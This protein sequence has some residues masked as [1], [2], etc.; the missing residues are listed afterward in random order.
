MSTFNTSIPGSSVTSVAGVIDPDAYP[1]GTYTTDWISLSTWGTLLALVLAGDLGAAATLDAK[2][3][4]A[5][6][7][8][9]TGAKEVTAKAITSLTKAGGDDN[10]Q[11]LINLRADDLD[12]NAGYTHA[13]LSLTI[14]TAACDAGA[15]VLGLNPRYGT[16]AANDLATVDEIIP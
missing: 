15:V 10:K 4:Q 11:A 1:P 14:A 9:G 5:T 8:S 7:A 3:E 2:M 12:V 16:A 6:S 13:R